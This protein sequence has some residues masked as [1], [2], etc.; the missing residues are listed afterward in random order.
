MLVSHSIGFTSFR[1]SWVGR[2]LTRNMVWT[3]ELL[4]IAPKGSSRVS[5]FLEKAADGLLEGGKE[6]IFTPMYFYK[7]QKP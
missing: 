4:G 7:V 2:L 1:T 5:S 6:K 3:L